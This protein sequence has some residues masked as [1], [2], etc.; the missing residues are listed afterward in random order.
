MDHPPNPVGLAVDFEDMFDGSVVSPTYRQLTEYQILISWNASPDDEEN[1]NGILDVPLDNLQ[2]TDLLLALHFSS[3]ILDFD[4]GVPLP[5]NIDG[6]VYV[7]GVHPTDA[8]GDHSNPRCHC[9]GIAFTGRCRNGGREK[10]W[11]AYVPIYENKEELDENYVA[12]R[13]HHEFDVPHEMR[14]ATV[15]TLVVLTSLQDSVF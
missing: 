11:D 9:K 12:L 8:A 2:P 13:I 10:Y 1:E 3:T 15:I 5:D 4:S 6:A 7:Y 14:V